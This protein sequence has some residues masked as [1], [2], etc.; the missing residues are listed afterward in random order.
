MNNWVEGA[1]EKGQN[2]IY[3]SFI[4]FLRCCLLFHHL[5]WFVCSVFIYRN[6]IS[7]RPYFFYFFGFFPRRC[8][9]EVNWGNTLEKYFL[10]YFHF[11]LLVLW[12]IPEKR[13]NKQ[14]TYTVSPTHPKMMTTAMRWLWWWWWSSLPHILSYFSS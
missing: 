11:L 9:T 7:S 5:H 12:Y 13:T 14:H 3:S 10:F 4:M 8:T 1:K 6:S 2:K